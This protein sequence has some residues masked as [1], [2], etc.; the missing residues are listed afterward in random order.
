VA[1]CDEDSGPNLRF[2]TTPSRPD[3]RSNRPAFSALVTSL[4]V[5]ACALVLFA[6]R[7]SSA[8]ASVANPQSDT[9]T[10][11]LVW[12]P[13]QGS[14]GPRG[15][16]GQR[17]PRP[18]QRAQLVGRDTLTLPAAKPLRFDSVT[19][20]VEPPAQQIVVPA[21]A[22]ASG[23]REAIGI[24]SELAPLDTGSGGPGD[25]PGAGDRAGRGSGSRDGP[26]LDDGDGAQAGDGV[27]WP[28]LVQE[29]KPNYTAD[30]LRA[31]VQGMVGL[32]IVVLPDGSV[33][34]VR[35]TRSLDKTF[36][37]DQEAIK[38][39]SRWRFEPGRRLGRAVPVRVGVE[40]SFMLR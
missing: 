7:F 13:T 8:P 39:V 18:V 24:V 33:G 28:R 32:E 34:R 17:T 12:V 4:F 29:V 2:L 36:G 31:R 37:L 14:D 20:E 5:H 3:R 16:G 25:G 38:A 19:P 15:T 6:M 21:P 35:V 1:P 23:L 10:P 22:V 30:A 26:G 27:S 40:M 11:R 9:R